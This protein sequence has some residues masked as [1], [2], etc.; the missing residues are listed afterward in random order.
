MNIFMAKPDSQRLNS[1]HFWAWKNGLKTGMYYLR[2]RP[3]VNAIKFTIN[4]NLENN[5]NDNDT[6]KLPEKHIEHCEHCSS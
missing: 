5:N 3:S 4:P 2:T 6:S 1:S